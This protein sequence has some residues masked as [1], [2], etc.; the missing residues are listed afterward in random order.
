MKNNG[1]HVLTE[2]E[3]KDYIHNSILSEKSFAIIRGGY[4]FTPLYYFQKQLY[5]PKVYRRT[6]R[7]NAGMYTSTHLQ[8]R[9]FA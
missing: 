1:I 9:R 4:E 6:L 7:N 5:I 8:F 2:K 3:S